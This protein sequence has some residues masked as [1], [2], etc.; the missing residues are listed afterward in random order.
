[1]QMRMAHGYSD[2]LT[3]AFDEL[4]HYVYTRPDARKRMTGQSYHYKTTEE[5]KE[6]MLIAVQHYFE[7]SMMIVRS[8]SLL[9][10]IAAVRW[11]ERDLECPRPNDSLMAAALAMMSY[12]QILDTDLGGA[13]HCRT[14]WVKAQRMSRGGQSIEEFSSAMLQDWADRR[15][16]Q[17]RAQ[18]LERQGNSTLTDQGQAERELRDYNSMRALLEERKDDIA[19]R[20]PWASLNR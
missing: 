14:D 11:K 1:M 16:M 15:I 9:K 8:M 19:D 10:Q 2:I 5:T 6:T 7:R 18:E 17:A 13:D 12:Q 20:M 4:E 3:R